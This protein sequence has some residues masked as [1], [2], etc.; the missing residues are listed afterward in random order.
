MNWNHRDEWTNHGDGFTILVSRHGVEETNYRTGEKWI[1][2]K[3]CVYVVIRAGHKLYEKLKDND[4]L[5]HP[6]INPMPLHG[7]CS[8]VKRFDGYIKIGCDYSHI[9]DDVCQGWK[10]RE[11]ALE[12]FIDAEQLYDYMVNYEP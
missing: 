6:D 3:W 4:G 1:A 5:W 11:N 2:N 12:V 9:N 7:G 10:T 8:Y